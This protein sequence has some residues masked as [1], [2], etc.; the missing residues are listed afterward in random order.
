[1]DV[2]DLRGRQAAITSSSSQQPR[3]PVAER[4]AISDAFLRVAT[5][6]RASRQ[7]TG[8]PACTRVGNR[9][10]LRRAEYGVAR[11]ARRLPAMTDFPAREPAKTED[12]R[13]NVKNNSNSARN[14]RWPVMLAPVAGD[15]ACG[16]AE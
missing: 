16:R 10:G 8:D 12:D 15:G 5:R 7:L 14:R 11:S 9:H 4:D 2:V 6:L 3:K 1:M 13:K